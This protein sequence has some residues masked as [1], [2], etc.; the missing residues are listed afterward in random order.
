[1]S[2]HPP[3]L[4]V[5]LPRYDVPYIAQ[6]HTHSCWYACTQMLWMYSHKGA[7]LGPTPDFTKRADV[8][9]EF[10]KLLAYSP[11]LDSPL[12]S[13]AGGR[14]TTEKDWPILGHLGFGQIPLKQVE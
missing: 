2:S 1:M 8:G 4:E 5:S 7:D 14:G 13:Q 3:K 10:S 11:L 9:S 6:L 12:E